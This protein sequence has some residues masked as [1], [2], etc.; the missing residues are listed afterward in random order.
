[1]MGQ[2]LEWIPLGS[3][4]IAWLE[5]QL[6]LLTHIGLWTQ[7]KDGE[8][9]LRRQ[10][11]IALAKSLIGQA[12]I[13]SGD[14][15]VAAPNGISIDAL[16]ESTDDV[17]DSALDA[18]ADRFF[19]GSNERNSSRAS[20]FCIVPSSLHYASDPWIVRL[21]KS[22]PLHTKLVFH[23]EGVYGLMHL[24]DG[25]VTTRRLLQDLLAELSSSPPAIGFAGDE[26]FDEC[27]EEM[28]KTGQT[29]D[30]QLSE[31]AIST[32]RIV[33]RVGIC[34]ELLLWERSLNT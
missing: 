22:L 16:I 19:F 6:E 11:S 13:K 30:R 32:S 20:Q 26:R 31:L 21:R 14:I 10:W 29:S 2:A 3:D 33:A 12:S 28:W 7:A 34:G 5:G 25:D 17:S 18:T 15:F 23:S 8:M 24:R 1:M 4:G 9:V 27:C